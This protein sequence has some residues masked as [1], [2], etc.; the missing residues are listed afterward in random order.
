MPIER[1]KPNKAAAE[2]VTQNA[3]LE[4]L[5]VHGTNFAS[6]GLNDETIDGAT[7]VQLTP[8]QNAQVVTDTHKV[9]QTAVKTYTTQMA[10]HVET[11]GK[12]KLDIS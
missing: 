12:S 5:K 1:K 7:T 6:G 10:K 9:Q 8:E 3:E 4:T 11:Y 2:S